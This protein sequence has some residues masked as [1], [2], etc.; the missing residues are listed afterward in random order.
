LWIC[1]KNHKNQMFLKNIILSFLICLI[2]I[3]FCADFLYD[4]KYVLYIKP[5]F[6]PL[7]LAY[8]FID[9]KK[10][11]PIKF[12]LFSLF[13]YLGEM[14]FLISDVIK[15]YLSLGLFFYFLSYLALINI[16]N[17]LTEKY[18]F[19]NTLKGY[20]LFVVIINCIFLGIVLYLILESEKDYLV[21]CLIILNTISAILLTI[22]TVYYLSKNYN[23]NSFYY[24]AGCFCIL[25]SDIF[26]AL[27][28][29]YINDFSLNLMDRFLHL[30]GFFSVYFYVI[31]VNRKGLFIENESLIN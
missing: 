2:A 6:I 9:L 7:L 29:Y 8:S 11:L 28:K 13:F 15:I 23:L 24:F 19:K 12:Y 30:L 18:N 5:F 4:P 26:A 17:P 3:Y 21:I 14:M 10:A 1:W 20:T 25:V 27:I 22:S 31:Q 16:V